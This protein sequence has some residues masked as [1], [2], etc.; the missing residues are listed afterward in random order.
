MKKRVPFHW[1]EACKKAF[2]SI[3]DYLTKPPVLTAPIPGHPLTL[4]IAAQERSVGV[5]LAQE[6]NKGKENA[7][8]Y[9]SRMMT[10]NKLNYSPVEKICL[11]LIFA[12]KKLKHYFQAHTIRLVSKTNPLKYVMSKPVLFDRLTRWYLQLQQFKIIYVPQKAVKGQILADFLADHPIPAEWELSDDFPDEDEP[13]LKITPPWKMYFDGSSHKNRAGAGVI[14]VTSQGEVLPYSFALKEKCSNNVAE[15]QALILG[16]K[17]AVDIKQR[18][19]Q[20]YEDSKLVVNQITREFGVKKPELMPYLKYAKTLIEL[21]GDV[22]IEYVPRKENGQADA[23]AKLASTLSIPDQQVYIPIRKV[24][25]DSY[26]YEEEE[27]V[28]KEVNHLIEEELTT[29]ENFRLR[30]GELEALDEKSLQAQQR[31]ECYQARL[32]RAYN[33]KVKSRSFQIGDLVLAVRRPIVINFRSE[34]KFLSKWD[35]PYIV[36]HVYTNGAYKLTS[37]DG[38]RRG[39]INGRFL[40]RYYA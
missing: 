27:C 24:W 9:L 19:L 12:I 14:F 25:V 31:L 33:K 6:A 17:M 21:L 16:L 15:Y 26:K 13:F 3:K 37:Q 5:L 28:E 10:P 30:L 20:V 39:P 2:Q 4:Y 23:L 18:Q 1:D 38:L 40:K 29:E 32:S 35:G 22:S 34:N 8:Y 7:L 36:T 11:A